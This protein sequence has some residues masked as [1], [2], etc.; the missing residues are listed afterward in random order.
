LSRSSLAPAAPRTRRPSLLLPL[1]VA[2][3]IASGAGVMAGLLVNDL[4]GGQRNVAENSDRRT[5]RPPEPGVPAAVPGDYPLASL[6]DQAKPFHYVKQDNAFVAIAAPRRLTLDALEG[7]DR[8]DEAYKDQQAYL[9]ISGPMYEASNPSERNNRWRPLGDLKLASRTLMSA[10]RAA[11][12]SRAF[13]AIDKEGKAHFG[14]GELTPERDQ[15]YDIFIGGLHALYNDRQ[16]APP[17]YRPAYESSAGQSVRAYLPRTRIIYGLT[18]RGNLVFVMSYGGWTLE[19][20]EKFSREQGLVAAYMP[21]HASKSRFIVPGKYAYSSYDV[22]G[23]TQG[24]LSF[25]HVPYM[26]R[27]ADY[28]A[29]PNIVLTTRNWAPRCNPWNCWLQQLTQRIGL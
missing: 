17:T 28:G 21:D 16:P 9:Y 8:E 29:T 3:G 7:W 5:Q 13:I 11:A 24:A 10:N 1:L 15:R 6:E 19:Q 20:A 25:A 18:P 22:N 23:P 4:T 27:L 26:L 14:Y 2:M 12:R